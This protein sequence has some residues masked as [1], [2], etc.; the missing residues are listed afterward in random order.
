MGMESRSLML[1]ATASSQDH[2]DNVSAMWIAMAG[3]AIS[4]FV[5]WVTARWTIQTDERR[6]LRE[7]NIRM[8]EW[9]IEYPFL[10]SEQFCSQWPNS[11]RCEDDRMRYENYCCHVF[12]LLQHC[13]EF[14]KGDHA[15]MKHI[16]YPDELIWAHRAWWRRDDVNQDAYPVAFRQ[17]VAERIR[18]MEK[19]KSK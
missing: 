15:K 16:L 10:E 1:L 7:S 18:T 13:W 17:Y 9:A 11:D 3:V 6:T 5:A 19:E 2:L 8:L 4:A 14:S 12:N